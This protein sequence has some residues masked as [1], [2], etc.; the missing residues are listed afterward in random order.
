MVMLCGILFITNI[1][2]DSN[3]FQMRWQN[4]MAY[5]AKYQYCHNAINCR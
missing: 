2:D 3:R 5:F 1:F 4:I